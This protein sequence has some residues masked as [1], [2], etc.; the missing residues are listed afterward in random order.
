M[1]VAVYQ[2]AS[3]D[4]PGDDDEEVTC[5]VDLEDLES[6]Y[7]EA[8]DGVLE[9][10]IE[11]IEQFGNDYG[12]TDQNKV[13]HFL[14]Q[15]AHET[16]GPPGEWDEFYSLEEFLDYPDAETIASVFDFAFGSEGDPDPAEYVNDEEK[17]A[18]YVYA[19][20]L[21]NGPP[22]SGD[23]YK[24]RGRGL[25]QLTGKNNY[26]EFSTYYDENH[27]PDAENQDF[28]EIPDL[29][30]S[31]VIAAMSALWYFNEE[32]IPLI[33]GEWTVESVTTAVAGDE[34]QGLED[35]EHRYDD[36]T[37]NITISCE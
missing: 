37:A 25:F 28:V 31:P 30:L 24:Y 3:A 13:E 17:L 6:L 5:E 9:A 20:W 8:A 35:R 32:V 34:Q 16:A 7:T 27:N 4:C 12:L 33:D 18:N 19:G 14:A 15:A 29:V 36:I 10:L 21:G 26:Q 1:A 23:G 22:E 11:A 2:P